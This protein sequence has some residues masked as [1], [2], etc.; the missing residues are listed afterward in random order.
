MVVTHTHVKD[1]GQKS[2]SL[3]DRVEVD[4]WTDGWREATALPPVLMWSIINN[5]IAN[6][7]DAGSG[8]A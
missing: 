7:Y 1:Q 6:S 5:S 8:R 4:G 2:V 3:K